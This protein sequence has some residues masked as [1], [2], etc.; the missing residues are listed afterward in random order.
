[1]DKKQIIMVVGVAIVL[2]VGGSL[3]VNSQKNKQA[4]T[5]PEQPSKAEQAKTLIDKLYLLD[6]NGGILMSDDARR[7]FNANVDVLKSLSSREL[8]GLIIVMN[9]M[10]SNTASD[11]EKEYLNELSDKLSL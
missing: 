2:I 6:H 7:I 5:Q 1:M 4:P 9:K 11:S 10:I 3:W 8:D